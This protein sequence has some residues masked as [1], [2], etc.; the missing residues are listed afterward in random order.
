MAGDEVN[1]LFGFPILLSEDVRTTKCA[2]RQQ[3]HC[4]AVTFHKSADVVA[5]PAVPLLP[6]VAD[7]ASDLIETGS[8]PWLRDQFGAGEDRIRLDVPENGRIFER[9]A[10]FVSGQD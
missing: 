7:K 8:V 1:A 2:L 3:M 9:A 5:K 10:C 4:A 6:A